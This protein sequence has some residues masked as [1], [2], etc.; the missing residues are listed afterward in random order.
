M[1]DHTPQRDEELLNTIALGAI[2]GV[3][4]VVARQL[5][6]EFGSATAVMR[7]KP[8]A[9]SRL[10]RVGCE[11]AAGCR[12]CQVLDFAEREV[13]FVRRHN[14]TTLL[15]TDEAYPYRLRECPDAPPLLFYMGNADLNAKH[16]ISVVGTRNATR[17]GRDMV[18]NLMRDLS[19]QLPDTLVVSGLAYGIDVS[20]HRAALREHLPTVAVMAHGLDRIYPDQHRH[21]AREMIADGGLLTEYPSHTNPDKGNFLARNRI[22]AGLADATIVVETADKGGSIVTASIADSYGRNIFAFPGRVGDAHSVGCNR[23][24]RQCKAGLITCAADLLD[25]MGWTRNTA[26]RQLEIPFEQA[27]PALSEAEQKV[28]DLLREHGDM[29]LNA[30]VA[31]T[32]KPVSELTGLLMGLQM[33]GVVAC[34]PGNIYRLRG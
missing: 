14:I 34:E 12:S 32:E 5:I 6:E 4:P 28:V 15:M 27:T 11:L 17:Y 25:E 7:E 18:D 24:I 19:S 22:V 13:D 20:A 8:E 1:T 10:P 23:L 29:Q 31:I 16:I 21:I 33:M 2:K 30:L 9:L 3:G 26:G